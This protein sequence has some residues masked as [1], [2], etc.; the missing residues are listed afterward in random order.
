MNYTIELL[1]LDTPAISSGASLL[2]GGTGPDVDDYPQEDETI[3]IV[4]GGCSDA[5]GVGEGWGNGDGSYILY[6]EEIDYAPE[7]VLLMRW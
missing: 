2:P 3:Q 5:L 4:D 1:D 6:G 7:V